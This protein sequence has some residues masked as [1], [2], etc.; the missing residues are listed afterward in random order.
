MVAQ[1]SFRPSENNCQTLEPYIFSYFAQTAH[2]L[3]V[4]EN[5]RQEV[6]RQL[7]SFEV[8]KGCQLIS[9]FLLCR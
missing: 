2:Q 3:T 6:M 8:V 1:T 5:N 7:R 9:F 4:Y